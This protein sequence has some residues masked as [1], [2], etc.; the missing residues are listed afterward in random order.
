M[1]I[2]LFGAA[3]LLGA[4]AACSGGGSAG[5]T[6]APTPGPLSVTPTGLTFLST[7]PSQAQI[8]S[9]TESWFS[10]PFT[11]GTGCSG[12]AAVTP[13]AGSATSFDVTP[14]AT[15]TCT[16]TVTGAPG[17][18]QSVAITVTTTSVGGH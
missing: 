17:Q 16:L 4:L 8:I 18:T 2:R 13:Q 14:N 5:P 1:K 3:A 9:A 11:F 7:G 12:I 6:P 10:G 15:G